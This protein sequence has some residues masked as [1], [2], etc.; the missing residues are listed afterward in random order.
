MGST[1]VP[2]N[3]HQNLVCKVSPVFLGACNSLFKEAL[4]GEIYL[5]EA[6]PEAF[7]IFMEW[8]YTGLIEFPGHP[9]N[10]QSIGDHDAWWSLVAKMYVL[11]HYL[12]ST[13]FGNKVIDFIV[14]TIMR[15]QVLQSPQCGVIDLVYSSTTGDCGLRKLF[16]AL[17]VW[18]TGPERWE[19]VMGWKTYLEGLPAEYSHDL[20][21]RLQRRHHQLDQDPFVSEKKCQIFRDAELEQQATKGWNDATRACSQE[22]E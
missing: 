21:V 8:V 5:S 13:S 6:D 1:K 14:C 20:V 11:A 15:K 4:S 9:P 17:T 19:E 10:E 16:V 18:R 7:D 22:P 12:Q 3:I 2:F